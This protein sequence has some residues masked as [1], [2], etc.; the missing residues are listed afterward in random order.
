M[1]EGGFRLSGHVKPLHAKANGHLLSLESERQR[2]H[3]ASRRIHWPD[4]PRNGTRLHDHRTDGSRSRLEQYSHSDFI[5][6]DPRQPLW[7]AVG[8]GATWESA[9][10]YFMDYVTL[11]IE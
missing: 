2:G 4:K 3:L 9:R 11:A 1:K 6:L 8:F 7:I 10:T 5:V